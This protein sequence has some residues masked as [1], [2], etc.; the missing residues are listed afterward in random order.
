MSL[1]DILCLRQFCSPLFGLFRLARSSVEGFG[2]ERLIT[3]NCQFRTIGEDAD[4]AKRWLL[5][6]TSTETLRKAGVLSDDF[7]LKAS[8]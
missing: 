2:C 5:G 6:L 1:P 8:V 7:W 3:A 4:D